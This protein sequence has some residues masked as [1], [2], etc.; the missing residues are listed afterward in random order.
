MATGENSIAARTAIHGSSGASRPAVM[1]SS[2]TNPTPLLGVD[3]PTLSW[4]SSCAVG[5]GRN[6][7]HC[8]A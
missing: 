5:M 4:A 2:F 8:C 3:C 6:N 1:L 7:K